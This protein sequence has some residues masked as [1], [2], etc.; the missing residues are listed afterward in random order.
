MRFI[1]CRRNWVD[2]EK[3][4]DGEV[5]GGWISY[6]SSA[7]IAGL[8]FSRTKALCGALQELRG[9]GSSG[10]RERRGGETA[11]SDMQGQSDDPGD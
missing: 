9:N 3:V 6:S 1:D 10:R 8:M 2:A 7:I 4:S 11:V 5:E